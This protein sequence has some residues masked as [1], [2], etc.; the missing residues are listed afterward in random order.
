MVHIVHIFKYSTCGTYGA[1]RTCGTC[2]TCVTYRTR[3]ATIV[4][5]HVIY[6]CI[7]MKMY[8]YVYILDCGCKFYR[9][10]IISCLLF[11]KTFKNR[12]FK[13]DCNVQYIT[14]L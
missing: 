10:E 8:T 4:T 9:S 11:E 6:R 7:V 13:L 5:I 3:D 14:V 2:G 12:K 1:C